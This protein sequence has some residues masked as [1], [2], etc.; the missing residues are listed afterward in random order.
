MT[1]RK[2]VARIRRAAITLPIVA[3]ATQATVASAQTVDP[4]DPDNHLG[5][6][7]L[8]TGTLDMAGRL[9]D[10]KGVR[11]AGSISA[12]VH[13]HPEDQIRLGLN[14]E[15]STLQ[16]PSL[17]ADRSGRFSV[18]V[19]LGTAQLKKLAALGA[20][21]ELAL[22][23]SSGN[24]RALHFTPLNAADGE[25]SRLAPRE[26]GPTATSSPIEL[27]MVPVA[28]SGA[29]TAE[30]S[31]MAT[32]ASLNPGHCV[33][34]GLPVQISNGN[35]SVGATRF[36]PE[37]SN[38]AVGWTYKRTN[39]TTAS[40]GVSFGIGGSFPV[41]SASFSASGSTSIGRSTS[42]EGSTMTASP[43]N[44]SGLGRKHVITVS[45]YLT[46]WNCLVSA[47][48]PPPNDYVKAYTVHAGSWVSDFANVE[49]PGG[50]APCTMTGP[51]GTGNWF[52]LGAGSSIT[53][54]SGSSTTYQSGFAGNVS[55]EAMSTSVNLSTTTA[56]TTNA[57]VTVTNT[58]T[59]GNKRLCGYTANRTP[60]FENTQW[61]G[62]PGLY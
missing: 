35:L 43:S 30:G 50:P 58:Y 17:E 24:E 29:P 6:E 59:T 22:S 13:V 55:F 3:I 11:Q 33:Q 53:R 25:S 41:G 56:F 4:V 48:I 14:P 12:A 5:G 57:K 15:E 21:L 20:R 26:I 46:K 39:S 19:D 27:S 44:G 61:V 2:H 38:W 36:A 37:A 8:A 62:M 23:A 49:I 32:A 1:N 10:S 60:L 31:G 52:L 34:V 51:S 42:L 45:R 28:A 7:R 16:L 54:E 9:T 47:S 40:A 18:S